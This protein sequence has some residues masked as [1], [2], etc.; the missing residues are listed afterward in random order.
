VAT[1]FAGPLSAWYARGGGDA[2]RLREGVEVWRRD[3]CAGLAPKVS[4][5]LVWDEGSDTTLTT[6]LGDAGWMALR[7]FAFYA[8]KPEF[9]MPDAVPGLLELDREWRAAA[10]AKFAT[11]RYGHLL[12]CTMWLPGDFPVTFKAPLPDG[13]S[14]EIGSVAVLQDQLRWLNE[15]TFQA[16]AH[17][18]ASWREL[19]APPGGDLLDAARRGY[20]ALAAVVGEAARERLAVVVAEV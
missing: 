18:I 16:S 7:L 10:D 6:D 8:E 3:L 19:T 1:A 4:E 5:Q 14:A 9:E 12:A 20:S 15:R 13:D 2:A 11:S 17:E